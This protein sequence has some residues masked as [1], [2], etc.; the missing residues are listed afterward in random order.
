MLKEAFQG[1]LIKKQRER[2][3]NSKN[4]KGLSI[5]N[6]PYKQQLSCYLTD[7]SE[8]GPFCHRVILSQSYSQHT[9]AMNDPRSVQLICVFTC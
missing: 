4:A 8:F 6:K 1:F 3:K 7:L 5:Q 9:P 2:K